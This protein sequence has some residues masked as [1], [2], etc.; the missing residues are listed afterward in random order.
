MVRWPPEPPRDG[1]KGR[2][3]SEATRRPPRA[4][5]GSSAPGQR[6]LEPPMGAAPST[7]GEGGA[8]Q[9]TGWAGVGL[10]HPV[11]RLQLGQPLLPQRLE[12]LLRHAAA[13]PGE[14]PRTRSDSL[15]RN[16][17]SPSARAPPSPVRR[18]PQR[19]GITNPAQSRA[20]R[21]SQCLGRGPNPRS[22][23]VGSSAELMRRHFQNSVLAPSCK[24]VLSGRGRRQG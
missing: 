22:Q 7:S 18:R 5:A 15:R 16:A 21:P 4:E 13:V 6:C 24:H 19:P 3:G 1:Q 20:A 17:G 9:G 2:D 14:Q 10:A 8:Q 12:L 23:V 11:L